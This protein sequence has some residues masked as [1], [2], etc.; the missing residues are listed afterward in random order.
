M[1][2]LIASI[3][4]T[5]SLAFG[6]VTAPHL[7]HQCFLEHSPFG[8][9]TLDWE[10]CIDKTDS[11]NSDDV[12]YQLHGLN[13][14]DIENGGWSNP[15]GFANEVRTLWAQMNFD[16]PTVVSVTFGDLWLLVEKNQSEV[17]GLYEF[18][19]QVAIP[20]IDQDLLKMG[21]ITNRELVGES[22]GGFNASQLLLKFPQNYFAKVALICPAIATLTPFSDQKE[23]NDYI[24]TTGADPDRVSKLL[25]LSQFFMPTPVDWSKA[26]PLDLAK[27]ILNE[28]SPTLYV[29][30][31]DKDEYGFFTG[32]EQF[33]EVAKANGVKAEWVP[34]AG[35]GHC[36]I[37][38][39]S[40]AKFLAE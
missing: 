19:T 37:D 33:Y 23:V 40:V 9:T 39:E 6:Q 38:A 2:I 28:D 15:N 7:S 26:S 27:T 34:I 4:L 18:F 24:Q 1:K 32:A 25:Q 8:T 35:Q 5:S 14:G 11:S 29:S 36:A 12:L 21:K 13:N 20:M 10:Y 3:L 16:A 31:G 22:M 30:C 17:S